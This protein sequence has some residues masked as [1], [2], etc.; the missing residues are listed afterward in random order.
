[1]EQLQLQF[2]L[3]IIGIGSASGLLFKDNA[4]FLISD[5]STYLYE[6]NL[7]S[8]ELNKIAL[9]EKPEENIPKKDKPDFESMTIVENEIYIFGS[10]STENRN[11]LRKFDTLN[12]KIIDKDISKLYKAIKTKFSIQDDEL[13]IEGAILHHKKM[14]LFQRGNSKNGLN[15]IFLVDNNKKAEIQFEKISLPKINNIEASFTDAILVDETIYFLASVENTTSTY[16]D[17]EILG[18]FIGQL[19]AN[20]LSLVKTQLISKKNKFEGITLYKNSKNNIEFLLCE[21]N[22]TEILE[23]NIY[24]LTINK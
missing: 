12:R 10:G 19:N 6:Y 11:S 4:L 16:E 17:G 21:D 20:D 15:G 3:Q 24:K 13:N 7:D 14:Y 23:S 9:V 8:N 1:M 5:N 2:F 18:T 22:D